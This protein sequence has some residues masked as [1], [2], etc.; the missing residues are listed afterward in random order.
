[1]LFNVLILPAFVPVAEQI[2]KSRYAVSHESKLALSLQVQYL[3]NLGS[4]TM[5]M[6]LT[7]G[8]FLPILIGYSQRER[9]IKGSL[10]E[11]IAQ[12]K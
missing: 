7:K 12:T 8:F 3:L 1:M 9:S 4:K 11:I 5:Y 2:K 10:G 6:Y